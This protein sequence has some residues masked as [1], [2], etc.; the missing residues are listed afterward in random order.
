VVVRCDLL[1]RPRAAWISRGRRFVEGLARAAA[2]LAVALLPP[3]SRVRHGTG[4][5][6]IG[7]GLGLALG[8]LGLHVVEYRRSG[9]LVQR[10]SRP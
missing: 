10:G 1:D 2:G 3:W 7:Y 6:Q 8:S 9:S 4:L 5:R